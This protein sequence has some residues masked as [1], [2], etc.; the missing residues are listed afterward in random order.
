MNTE[1]PHRPFAAR[2]APALAGLVLAALLA[3]C[4]APERPTAPAAADVSA[5]RSAQSAGDWRTAAGLWEEAALAHPGQAPEFWLNAAEAWLKDGDSANARSAIDRASPLPDSGFDATRAALTRAELALLDSDVQTAEFFLDAAADGLPSSLRARYEADLARLATLKT[6]PASRALADARQEIGSLRLDR[7]S[8]QLA[9]LRALDQVPTHRLQNEVRLGSALA[10]WAALTLSIRETLV[11]GQELTGA[12]A[13]W[14]ARQ[15]GHPVDAA[16]YMDLCW[17]LGQS[18]APPSRV[19]VL[20]P[21]EG[22]L[23]AAGAAIRDGIMSAWMERPGRS[24]VTFMAVDET[25]ASVTGAY[26]AAVS[27]GYQWV[28]G[29]LRRESVSLLMPQGSVPTLALNWPE[30]EDGVEV[31]VAR[32]NL[33]GLTLSQSEEARAV[34]GRM[35]DLGYRRVIVMLSDGSWSDRAEAAFTQAFLA[36]GGQVV[37][38]ERFSSTEADH[39]AQLTRMLRIE[40]SRQRRQK[41]QGELNLPLEFEPTRRDDFDAFFMA[42]EPRMGR[43]LKPQLKFFD[44][45]SVPVFAMSRVFSGRIDPGQDQDLDGIAFP[46]TAWSLGQWQDGELASLQSLRGGTYGSLYA[47]GR[48]AWN[49]LPWL[50]LMARDPAFRYPGTVGQLTVRPDGRIGREP[51]WAHFQRGR[52]TAWPAAATPALTQAR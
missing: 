40:A 28:I 24:E 39:S 46:T 50:G 9:L 37:E 29:P 33:Y 26:Q 34:A 19:A 3:A 22:G 30:A 8:D 51:V 18:Y 15:P 27:G 1:L 41:L 12:A 13:A 4:A 10:P 14:Q 38:T 47:L 17:Q 20:L 42:V 11:S 45:G 36:G 49:V 32:D 6:D 23:G 52:P 35:L 44:A 43:Q 2:R 31:P 21:E 16:G 48:D 7:T 25:A 5:A